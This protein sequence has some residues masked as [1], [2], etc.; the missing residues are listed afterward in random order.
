MITQFIR[1][2]LVFG[3][4]ALP[5][6]GRSGVGLAAADPVGS[7]NA[8]P[9]AAAAAALLNTT[10]RICDNLLRIY[11]CCPPAWLAPLCDLI[12]VDGCGPCV[13]PTTS[14]VDNLTFNY[15]HDA[16]DF[17]SAIHP[18]AAGAQGCVSC[19][20]AGGG[21]ASGVPHLDA[22]TIA[23][24]HRSRDVS[25][26]SSF[27]PGVYLAH[28]DTKLMLATT[29]SGEQFIDVLRPEEMGLMH[30]SD[31]PWLNEWGYSEVRDGIYH[32]QRTKGVREI[33]LL[34]ASG[35]PTADQT[36]A[37]S[38]RLI[39]HSGAE[40][41]F[42]IIDLGGGSRAGRLVQSLDRNGYATVIA[43]AYQPSDDLGGSPA[44]LWQIASVTDAYGQ[45]ATFTYASA[46]VSG[47]W[48]VSAIAL[49]N[50]TSL[51]Y[52]YSAGY[53]SSI[54]EADGSTATF[55]RSYDSISGCIVAQFADAGAEGIHRAK[56]VYLTTSYTLVEQSGN[57]FPQSAQLCR[58]VVNGA[59]E[60]A[61]LNFPHPLYSLVWIHEG[62][63]AL[64]HQWAGLTAQY[65][66]TWDIKS[67][68]TPWQG[69]FPRATIE[70]KSAESLYD[71]SN[72]WR[73][74]VK[75]EASGLRDERGK[76]VSFT[77]D[78][79]GNLI[80]R[81]HA[82]GSTQH[83]SYNAFSQVIQDEDRLGR[84]TQ[85]AYDARGN[86]L[87]QTS[88]LVRDGLGAVVPSADVATRSWE[89]IAAGQPNQF[90]LAASIDANG[91]RTDY[92]YDA[93]GRL[94]QIVEPADIAGGARATTTFTYD[95]QKRVKTTSDPAGRVVSYTYDARNRI[96]RSDF[97]D[98][99]WS[100]K[101]F[102][103]GADVNLCVAE[104]DRDGRVTT[105]AYDGAGR[106]I[107]TVQGAA[108]RSVGGVLTASSRN[109]QRIIELAYLAGTQLV[110]ARSVDGEL[111]TTTYDFRNRP[112]ATTVSLPGGQS[113]VTTNVYDDNNQLAGVIDPYGRATRY[114]Y[115]GN[116]RVIREVRELVPNALPW[117]TDLATLVR[118]T[119]ANPD[120]VITDTT[121]DAEGQVLTRSDGRGVVTSF[122]YTQRGQLASQTEAAGTSVAGVT[123]MTY[124]AE[125]NL[126]SQRSPRQVAD[127]SL[128][129]TV[130]TYT[131][132]NLLATRTEAAGT[133][134]AM[135]TAFSYS[136]TRKIAAQTV[137][138]GTALA[139]TTGYTYGVCCDRLIAIS[140]AAG[141]VT[142]FA[143]D[144][145]G[146]R[147]TVTDPL[148][149]ATVTAYDLLNRVV[150]V[151]NPVGETTTV[152]YD[153]DLT[154]G[155]GPAYPA[156][157]AA[158]GFAVSA[159]GSAVA[160]TNALGQTS[161][162]IRDGLGRAR[163]RIDPLGHVTTLTYDVVVD[164][165][166]QATQT[167]PLGHASRAQADG[168][169]LQRVAIDATGARSLFGY[170]AA[171]NRVT[172]RDANGVG[173]DCVIDARSRD[174]ACTDT[175]GRSTAKT[176]DANGNVLTQ[177][178]GLGKLTS[179]VYDARDR[180]TSTTDR[181]GAVTGYGYDMLGNLV[182]IL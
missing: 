37:V 18:G 164:G 178:D 116:H 109:Q 134:I 42:E 182:S 125:G 149:H 138:A 154:D 3:I 174:A 124:D 24:V 43:Y 22:L 76:T 99:S 46:Q 12:K 169:G 27:G 28:Y 159:D 152:T 66:K 168:A 176:F 15:T 67:D 153:P 148:G 147:T 150:A 177:S 16:P 1:A 36:L 5:W 114:R 98:G 29:T 65:A 13:S 172:A 123:A 133:A 71:K 119:G 160:T 180:R 120:Y 60:V 94:I 129:A 106:V 38:A 17:Q 2:V 161:L 92:G 155:L 53:L 130:S 10:M 58:M 166:V 141:F 64:R 151:N 33:R 59:G 115:D 171:G 181:I 156:A 80:S 50:G 8:P 175:V 131:C 157:V 84:I 102:G 44:R 31:G 81:S 79:A 51:A 135:T 101:T 179:N 107:R 103:A 100:G 82:D 167:D 75:L 105:R 35:M 95:A 68:D 127:A 118:P 74:W 96:V 144:F 48:V 9:N 111:T 55:S 52:H 104:S 62:G 39:R 90:R 4:L 20:S 88:G 117:P 21:D 136:P 126:L 132:R 77:Y 165:L 54:D 40:M 89:Y 137:A 83:L 142:G 69:D 128:G 163:L 49:P 93:Q 85:S 41:I 173:L 7:N 86:R 146:N 70:S 145:N 34:D 45:V 170:D 73:N 97:P 112:L 25:Y 78:A 143:Y 47:R 113:L 26:D 57:I 158:V 6:A 108:Q 32:D 30:C 56:S 72:S 122:M 11:C 110:S 14:T 87:S 91:K 139:Q 63:H 140:D 19:G 162:D 61:Y 23:R 121:Y